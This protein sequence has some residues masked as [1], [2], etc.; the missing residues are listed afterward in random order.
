MDGG[1][2][3]MHPVQPGDSF[4]YRF[5]VPDAGFYWY[6][7]H[8]EGVTYLER[9][10]YGPIIVHAPDEQAPDCDLPLMLDDV[11]L[12]EDTLQIA[13]PDT[14]MMQLMGRLGNLLMVNGRADR[15]IAV[16]PGETVLMRLV[17]PSNARFWD[18]Y[19]EGQDLRVVGTDGGFIE[20]PYD[21][22]H[23]V[24]APG[25]RY[26][27]VFTAKGE[28]GAEVRL[29]NRRFQLHEEGGHMVEVDPLGN[30][31]NPAMTFVLG[32]A[33]V[34]GTPWVQPAVTPLP[35]TGPSEILGHHWLLDEV[36][37][38]GTVSIDGAAWP[39]VPLVSVT[40][41]TATTFVVEN[42]S[43]MHHP[44]HIHGNLFQIVD[45]NGAA[46]S[47]PQGWKDTWDVPP[48]STVTVVSD[49]SNP[50]DWMYHCHILEHAE[51]GMMGEMMVE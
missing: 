11:L 16:D 37:D 39:D 1:M 46:P 9:G 29:M 17:N 12:D 49:L 42:L 22:E 44:F 14:D 40:A 23:L 30:G 8:L 51:G 33:A 38:E 10:L 48:R 47:T 13:P 45:Q 32:D 5:T 21:V 20:T 3:M 27:V 26:L 34:A 6:H 35:Y 50:G 31:D 7:P 24:V 15:R 28:P 4:D 41:N 19:V 18:I 36:M 43:E 25:E 2:Q